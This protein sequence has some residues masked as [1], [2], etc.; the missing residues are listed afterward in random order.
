[1][2]H[3]VSR[4]GLLALP[5]L[6]VATPALAQTPG[7][8]LLALPTR[9]FK[10]P[11][12]GRE[13]TESWVLWL[14]VETEV[15]GPVILEGLTVSLS[16]GGRPLSAKTYPA[17]AAQAL[18]IKPPLTPRRPDGSAPL[19]PIYWPL[20][21]RIRCTEPVAAGVDRMVVEA[22]LNGAP[23]LSVLPVETYGQKTALIF[24]FRGK[25]V[26]TQA[27]VTNGGHRNRSGQFALDGVGLDD[28]YGV[29]LPGGGKSADYHGWG[30]EI[31]APADA[32]VVRAR[33]D[34]PD[35]PDP[36]ASDPKYYAPDYPNGG[37]PGN[38]LILD[39]GSGEFSLLAHLQA[40]SVA[41]AVGDRVA[42]GQVL[43]R[44]GSSGDTQTPHLHYQLQSGPDWEWA[45]SLPCRFSNVGE[46]HLVRGTYFDAR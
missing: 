34:R 22:R 42:Q 3:T 45:D 25:G 24:P 19:R 12:P 38:Y 15:D 17:A 11:D 10:T 28:A 7:V 8:R 35:Q 20:A 26:I 5:A 6:A 29:S 32:T 4:R 2:D 37:D 30:R 43:G 14:F 23:V 33:A 46:P 40:G 13:R 16:G 44:L 1:M 18:S 41:V 31:I 21:I 36:E 39:H 27:G 9:V